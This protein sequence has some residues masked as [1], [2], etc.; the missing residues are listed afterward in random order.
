MTDW[1]LY[2]N[3]QIRILSKIYTENFRD[4]CNILGD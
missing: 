3:I 4:N 2:K 1:V